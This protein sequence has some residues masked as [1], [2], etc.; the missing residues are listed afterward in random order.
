[1]PAGTMST[2]CQTVT[3]GNKE[4]FPLQSIFVRFMMGPPSHSHSGF[5][6]SAPAFHPGFQVGALLSLTSHCKPDAA[7]VMS[8]L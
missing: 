6:S 8:H 1:M 5:S 7:L 3:R 2:G 4:V